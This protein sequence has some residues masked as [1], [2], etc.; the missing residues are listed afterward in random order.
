MADG[1]T[2]CDPLRATALPLSVA[3]VALLVVH[4]NV[5]DSPLWIDTGLAVSLA[6]GWSG[7]GGGGGGAAVTVTTVVAV[8]LPAAL[9]ATSV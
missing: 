8:V 3:L 2:T 5:E 1:E 9:V 7:D 6:V 4:V